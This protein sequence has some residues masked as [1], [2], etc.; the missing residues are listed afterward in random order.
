V[1]PY[2]NRGQ[3]VVIYHHHDRNGKAP[4]QVRRQLA[5]LHERLDGYQQIHALVFQRF[6]L[7]TFFVLSTPGH[8]AD[9][10]ARIL[11][12]LDGPWAQHFSYASAAAAPPAT[13]FA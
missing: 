1:Q 6:S 5:R 4:E 8:D 2:L 10:T 3:S 12:F 7:R 13:S 11:R 9:L